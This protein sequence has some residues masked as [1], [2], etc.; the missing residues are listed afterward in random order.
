MTYDFTSII[1]RTG[2]D[3]LAVDMPAMERMSGEGYFAVPMKEGFDAIPMWVA[4][5]NFAT[6]PTIP[7]AIKERLSHPVYGYFSPRT[8]YFDAIL[9]CPEM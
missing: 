6:V 7:E 9:T 1:E 5:M 3:A 8:E 2:K 4:D